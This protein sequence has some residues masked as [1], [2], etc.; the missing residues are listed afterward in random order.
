MILVHTEE[1]L[2][3]TNEPA[4]CVIGATSTVVKDRFTGVP[5]KT[6]IRVCRQNEAACMRE[7]YLFDA[8]C[9]G[10]E[11]ERVSYDEFRKVR[12]RLVFGEDGANVYSS[13][14]GI[15]VLELRKMITGKGG[16]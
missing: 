2:E 1:E 13:K 10:G 5:H 9:D 6:Y 8:A 12:S 7:T 3:L 14:D 15:A 16:D 11:S 4:I